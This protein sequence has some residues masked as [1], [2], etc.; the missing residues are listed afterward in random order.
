MNYIIGI[1]I[2]GQALIC[3]SQSDEDELPCGLDKRTLKRARGK[4]NLGTINLPI[5]RCLCKLKIKNNASESDSDNDGVDLNSVNC[6]GV[7]NPDPSKKIDYTIKITRG[8]VDVNEN[9]GEINSYIF[10]PKIDDYYGNYTSKIIKKM[11][12]DD[13]LYFKSGTMEYGDSK[14]LINIRKDKSVEQICD[15]FDEGTDQYNFLK[16]IKYVLAGG[17]DCPIEKDTVCSMKKDYDPMTISV[18]DPWACGET[19]VVIDLRDKPDTENSGI[20]GE[21]IWEVEGDCVEQSKN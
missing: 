16:I 14:Y 5:L 20:L 13:C 12:K 9:P 10:I 4:L 15:E 11:E 3:L 18:N 6:D 8:F 21:W 7:A 19:S 17:N 1:F 2:L